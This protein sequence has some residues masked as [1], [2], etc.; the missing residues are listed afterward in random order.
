MGFI[1]YFLE[2]AIDYFFAFVVFIDKTKPTIDKISDLTIKPASEITMAT[3]DDT[4]YDCAITTNTPSLTPIPLIDIGSIPV[5]IT[6]IILI[7]MKSMIGILRLNGID[8]MYVWIPA[9]IKI[10]LLMKNGTII[11]LNLGMSSYNNS[12]DRSVISLYFFGIK[13]FMSILNSLFPLLFLSKTTN[14]VR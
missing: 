14:I 10:K 13:G 1:F 5:A 11:S 9:R 2:R 8:I 7:K 6:E 3:S 4:P 12:T